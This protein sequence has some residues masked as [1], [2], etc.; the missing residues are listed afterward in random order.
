MKVKNLKNQILKMTVLLRT[1]VIPFLTLVGGI[2]IR[3][4]LW[5]IERF[6]SNE[7]RSATPEIT[8]LYIDAD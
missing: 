1:Q 2:I 4:R 5:L 8:R 3:K 6:T 7:D